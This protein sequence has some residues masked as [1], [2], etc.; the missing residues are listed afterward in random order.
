[1]KM[2]YIALISLVILAVL[3]LT[4]LGTQ[5]SGNVISKESGIKIGLILPLSGNAAYYGIQA[6]R[7]AE[8]A[9]DNMRQWYPSLNLELIYEDSQYTP[10]VGVDAYNKLK[11]IDNVDAVIPQASPVSLAIQPL[12]N[13]DNVLEM[14]IASTSP[15]YSTYNDLS[16][17]TIPSMGVQTA[18]IIDFLEQ[19]QY[20]RLGILAVN[21]DYG[22]GGKESFKKLMSNNPALILVYEQDFSG[23]SAD[24]RTELS[25]L[26]EANPDAVYLVG[27]AASYVNILEQAKELG[28]S[29]KFISVASTESPVLLNARNSAEGIVY[30]YYDINPEDNPEARSFIGAYE[31]RYGEPPEGYAAEGYEAVRLTTLAFWK[32]G[33]KLECVK[34]YLENLRNYTSVF[35][36]LSFDMNGDVLYSFIFKTVSD[37]KFVALR[38]NS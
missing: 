8:I 17:R 26:K 19:S 37:G 28:I 5:M 20:R 4:L 13:R 23:G 10:K 33:R 25:K 14:A 16:F 27:T 11:N 9:K 35:G 24:F 32:C 1:M 38:F 18:K 7:G 12:A 31:E 21:D 30:T 15:K 29:A 6:Q 22:R 2:K 34:Y 3:I 36:N